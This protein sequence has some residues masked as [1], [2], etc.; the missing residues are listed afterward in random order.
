M[1]SNK[2]RK[3]RLTQVLLFFITIVT[4]TFAGA[5]WMYGKYLF[6]GE[7]S[8]TQEDF[9]NGFSFSIPFL[10]ILTFHE[11]GHYF[12]AQYHKVKVTLPFYLPLWFGFIGAPSLGTMGAFIK[13]QDQI[14]SRKKYF[15]I[16]IAGPLAGF[17]VAFFVIFYGF[18]N[19]PEPEYVYNVHP[20]YEQFGLSYDEYVYDYDYYV[21]RHKNSY[22]VWRAQ[23]SLSHL[24]EGKNISDWDYPEFT[25]WEQYESYHIGTNLM[26]EG[27]KL[28]L[29]DDYDRFPNGYELMHY[30]FVFAGFLALFFTALNLLPIGQLDGG[31]I[32]YGLVGYKNHR[33]VSQF[34]FM[35][36][37]YWAGLGLINPFELSSTLLSEIVYLGFLYL[38]FYRFSE[39]N[40]D[41]LM[42]GLIVFSLQM[43]TVMLFPKIEGY[44]GWLLFAL[45]LG[46][47]FGIYHP[48]VPID[49][50]LDN[51]RKVL[52]WISL[53]VFI[54]SF[55][56]K[57]LEVK[58]IQSNESKSD[59]PIFLSDTKPSPNL[60]RMDMPSSLPLASSKAINS[61][62][63][64][65]VFEASP[66]GSKN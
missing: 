1:L 14:A 59:T 39:S 17:V 26:F 29:V 3:T 42:Y 35:A 52:G 58:V 7:N 43:A 9:L 6:L 62:E 10:L 48:P 63:E 65:K 23:D 66:S 15:D 34:L 56:P 53:I 51:K 61:G 32:L 8:L 28:W 46:R 54:I 4:T 13:I 38:C 22:D 21:I 40:K 57:P 18:T 30:P 19:L 36:F 24:I 33:V 60:T 2:E 64:I 27:M 12:M 41:R 25:P 45:I 44:A 49:H 55:S 5:E 37:L 11:F 50:P 16:G 31:H 20:D 47:F